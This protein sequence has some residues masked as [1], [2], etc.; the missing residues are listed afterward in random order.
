MVARLRNGRYEERAN[1]CHQ[2]IGL[3]EAH[4][5]PSLAPSH[6]YSLALY[7]W[8]ETCGSSSQTGIAQVFDLNGRRLRVAQ[9]IDWDEHFD[10]SQLY[11]SYDD[12]SK[13]LVVRTAHYVPGDAHCCVSAMDVITLRWSGTKFVRKL[14]RTELSDYGSRQSKK[15]R[16]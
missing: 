7:T 9:Q 5:L 16:P 13:A 10:T 12:K 14:M 6:Q 8:I 11:V 4:L 1:S 3:D 15:I 2:D